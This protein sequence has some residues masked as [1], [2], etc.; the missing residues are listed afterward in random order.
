MASSATST[1]SDRPCSSTRCSAPAYSASYFTST[2]GVRPASLP[3]SHRN[4][5]Y[6]ACPRVSASTTTAG[7]KLSAYQPWICATAT[8]RLINTLWLAS[9]V[10]S[11]TVVQPSSGFSS[12][13]KAP[14]C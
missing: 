14:Y 7:A 1:R 2:T 6:V 3:D 12:A 8:A 13:V 5:L 11:P 10:A 9:D 4:K